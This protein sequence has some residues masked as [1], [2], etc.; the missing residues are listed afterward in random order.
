MDGSVAGRHGA[1]SVGSVPG[2][3]G[4]QVPSVGVGEGVS[5]GDG[6]GVASGSGGAVGHA[7]SGEGSGEDGVGSDGVGSEDVGVEDGVGSDEEGSVDG[8]GAAEVVPADGAAASVVVVPVGEGDAEADDVGLADFV[9]FAWSARCFP[10]LP[11]V[12]CAVTRPAAQPSG[13]ASTAES[14]RWV[15]RP[16]TVVPSSRPSPANRCW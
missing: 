7:L 16:A 1:S 8:D 14:A 5:V 9:G 6:D 15:G 3:H 12:A 4:G 10:A 13:V 2:G 11:P